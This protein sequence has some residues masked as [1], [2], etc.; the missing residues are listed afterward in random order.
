[1]HG[2]PDEVQ[3]LSERACLEGFLKRF[4]VPFRV[5]FGIG[6]GEWSSVAFV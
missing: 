6:L 1:M 4:S 2:C 5:T 3:I